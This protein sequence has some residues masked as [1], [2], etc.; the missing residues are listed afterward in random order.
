MSAVKQETDLNPEPPNDDSISVNTEIT[1]AQA[2]ATSTTNSSSSINELGLK[3]DNA[4]SPEP[5][6][7][8][9]T[10][11]N[12]T[13]NLFLDFTSPPTSDRV[14]KLK[15]SA[16]RAA[17]NKGMGRNSPS[18]AMV[19]CS[20]PNSPMVPRR[21]SLPQRS[22]TPSA[23]NSRPQTPRNPNTSVTVPN[24]P[25]MSRRSSLSS[26]SS[27]KSNKSGKRKVSNSKPGED[28]DDEDEDPLGKKNVAFSLPEHAFVLPDLK[29]TQEEFV[30]ELDDPFEGT[31][32]PASSEA[33]LDS[34][35]EKRGKTVANRPKKIGPG[36]PSMLSRLGG[37]QKKSDTRT[38]TS[39]APSPAP[40]T[41]SRP[42]SPRKGRS[43]SFGAITRPSTLSTTGRSGTSIRRPITPEPS[44]SATSN[45]KH[46]SRSAGGQGPAGGKPGVARG[47][48]GVSSAA[49]APSTPTGRK[50]ITGSSTLPRRSTKSS[51]PST[52]TEAKRGPG[53][54]TKS[55]S[56]GGGITRSS[57][58]K[59]EDA[60]S[61][62]LPLPGIL[63]KLLPP[64]SALSVTDLCFERLTALHAAPQTNLSRCM[65]RLQIFKAAIIVQSLECDESGNIEFCLSF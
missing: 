58:L 61:K 26:T 24:T 35:G 46:T 2:T 5:S 9:I 4:F 12:K 51:A 17:M 22:A 42:G 7:P 64:A 34:R 30:D 55:S 40:D 27:S 50:V 32:S 63:T 25:N 16:E 56:S 62:T 31:A 41:S 44:S 37:S 13:G 20:A 3:C 15:S 48:G 53:P 8:V 36:P 52:P 21:H 38:P 49:S 10:G 19:S 45:Y 1:T 60:R 28:V 14:P 33:S 29:S 54:N 23:H 65:F 6:V 43:M 47:K 39:P 11:K 57:S 59:G 18:T